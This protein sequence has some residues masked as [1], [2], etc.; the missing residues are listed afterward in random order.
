MGM[1]NLSIAGKK[2]PLIILF[3]VGI[4]V[5]GTT[6]AFV[7]KNDHQTNTTATNTMSPHDQEMALVNQYVRE[8]NTALAL[9]HAQKALAHE[10]DNQETLLAVASLTSQ[11]N[12]AEAKKLYA[13]AF[14]MFKKHDN[15]EESGKTSI[16]YWAAA[17]LAEQAGLVAE[18]KR[19]YQKV[20]DAANLSD[21]YQQSLVKQSQEALKRLQ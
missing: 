20:I 15:P 1:I 4:L 17:G 3:A 9:K 14:E 21:G 6:F 12:P 5:V 11:G 19:Y 8:K 18:A 7:N 10:P 2:K 16:T 13:Q